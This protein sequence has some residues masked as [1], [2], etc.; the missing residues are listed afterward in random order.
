ME[1]CGQPCASISPLPNS[2]PNMADVC[3]HSKHVWD[4]PILFVRGSEL[5]SSLVAPG[6]Y[7]K[8]ILFR[9]FIPF[10]ISEAFSSK[11]FKMSAC[12]PLG[13]VQVSDPYVHMEITFELLHR[14]IVWSMRCWLAFELQIFNKRIL[15]KLV[16]AAAALPICDLISFWISPL[17][18]ILLPRYV[19]W[20]VGIPLPS[21]VILQLG[22][23]GV[24]IRLTL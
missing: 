17:T 13:D 6:I 5:S 22:V 1:L 18:C 8:P 3:L 7:Y 24:L 21:K 10:R 16:N 19:N 11:S 9:I 20:P 4:A 15:F 14:F 12:V 2:I 23:A